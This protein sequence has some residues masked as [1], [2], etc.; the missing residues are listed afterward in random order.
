MFACRNYRVGFTVFYLVT[1][2]AD[3]GYATCPVQTVT[4][5]A[6]QTC[7]TGIGFLNSTINSQ[8][9][10]CSIYKETLYCIQKKIH[11]QGLDCDLPDIGASMAIIYKT[12][13][14]ELFNYDSCT[15]TPE[16][17]NICSSEDRL[18]T[19]TL[20][21]CTPYL[22]QMALYGDSLAAC[23]YKAALVQCAEQSLGYIGIQC[24]KF[25]VEEAFRS[26]TTAT[27]LS[28]HAFGVDLGSCFKTVGT[29]GSSSDKNCVD[30]VTIFSYSSVTTCMASLPRT[31]F[32]DNMSQQD[33]NMQ[34]S[35]VQEVLACMVKQLAVIGSQCT[36]KQMQS[37]VNTYIHLSQ[38]GAGL[39][40]IS[41]CQVNE[42]Y[43]STSMCD[44]DFRLVSFFATSGGT[45][46]NSLDGYNNK[47]LV[48]NTLVSYIG[49]L[50]NG[51]NVTCSSSKIFAAFISPFGTSFFNGHYPH[52]DFNHCA[53]GGF[54]Q[55]DVMTS[56]G[57][58]EV[59]L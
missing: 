22:S 57:Q 10:I 36:M 55:S 33:K 2:L 3:L 58:R 21:A 38:M 46:F 20:I 23:A 51:F 24:S 30:Y 35:F 34:C 49:V 4:S 45:A 54:G 31:N 42:S 27:F 13:G 29:Q 43:V 39:L 14:P 48:C 16:V 44:D 5:V 40:H 6:A 53:K 41:E 32:T 18:V 12:I 56:R 52:L 26:H 1:V 37:A 25:Q 19:Y 15:L 17:G 28:K 50:T 47:D 8:D 59:P 11:D 7:V 9:E